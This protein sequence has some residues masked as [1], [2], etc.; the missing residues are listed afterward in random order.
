ME[1]ASRVPHHL[2]V[3]SGKG[4]VGKSLISAALSYYLSRKGLKVLLYDADE[5][6]SSIPYLLGALNADVLVSQRTGKM[7]PPS[8]E[9]NLFFFSVEFFMSEQGVPL[10][11]EGAMRTRFIIETLSM[12]PM[13]GFDLIIYDM[14]PGTGDELIT[15]SQTLPPTSRGLIVSMPGR[16]SERVVRKAITFSRRAGLQII[17]LVEN[18]SYFRCPSGRVVSLFGESTLGRL[19]SEYGIPYGASLPFDPLI[20]EAVDK[21]ELLEELERETEFTMNLRELTEVVHGLLISSSQ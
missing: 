3:H 21:G 19:L 7:I 5:T 17:G 2:L 10:L 15:L 16:L 20:R 6:G 4:G 1:N 12:L 8:K 13:E 14:P 11:W 18:M 9:G